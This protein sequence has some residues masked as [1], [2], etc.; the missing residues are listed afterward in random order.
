M[1]DLAN[2]LQAELDQSRSLDP[3]LPGIV[4]TV[5]A[6]RIGLTWSGASDE[7]GTDDGASLTPGHAFRIASVTK[8]FTAAVALRLCEQRRLDLFAPMTRWLDPAI[9]Q[10]MGLAGYAPDRI[11]LHHL[12]THGS[13]L[14][15]HAA[16]DTDFGQAVMRDPGRRWTHAEQIEHCMAMGGPLAAPGIRF[17]YSDTGYILLGDILERVAQRPLHEL[18]R[19]QLQF[20]RLGLSQ[21]HVERHEAPPAGQQRARQLLGDRDASDFDCSCDLSGGGGL[22]STTAELALFFRSAVLGELFDHRQTLALALHTPNLE[23]TPPTQALHSTL[24]R[25]RWVGDE[26]CWVHGGFWGALAVYAPA[27]D[28]AMALSYGQASAGTVTT[29]LPGDPGQPSLA[30]RLARIAQHACRRMN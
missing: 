12:L 14:R 20:G 17:S 25:S 23:Y 21:T 8:P 16:P 7:A 5:L 1:Q 22:V 2:R 13:G 18:M 10:A 3:S 24:M 6:P 29:G 26:P 4:A 11:T 19:E 9:R 28:L 30:D 27:S 15:D